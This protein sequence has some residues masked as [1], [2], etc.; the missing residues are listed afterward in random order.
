M[1]SL[2]DWSHDKMNWQ[3]T[4]IYNSMSLIT[5]AQFNGKWN[6]KSPTV[7]WWPINCGLHVGLQSANCG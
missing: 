3:G 4:K 2:I 6:K 5:K 7:D 1:A